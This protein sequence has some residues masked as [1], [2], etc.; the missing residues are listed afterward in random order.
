M[1]LNCLRVN[2]LTLNSGDIIF[3][4]P[5]TA[6]KFKDSITQLHICYNIM[7]IK[8]EGHTYYGFRIFRMKKQFLKL[9][10]VLKEVLTCI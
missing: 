6:K 10:V 9:C 3:D 5:K 2:K 4:N 7:I 8:K 1:E